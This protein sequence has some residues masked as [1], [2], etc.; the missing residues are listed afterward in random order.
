MSRP[1]AFRMGI[2][3]LLFFSC[4]PG[5]TRK[6]WQG[7]S[8]RCASAAQAPCA[9]R[10]RWSTA[11]PP[12]TTRSSSRLSRSSPSTTSPASRKSTC[13]RYARPGNTSGCQIVFGHVHSMLGIHW[14]GHLL[15]WASQNSEMDAKLE[16]ATV[17]K[18]RTFQPGVSPT[19]SVRNRFIVGLCCD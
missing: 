11:R 1:T 13:S 3:V 6:N 7:F 4:F 19:V 18:S 8:R 10:R 16:I 9:G 14:F 12:P 15:L 17:N 5:W 2:L